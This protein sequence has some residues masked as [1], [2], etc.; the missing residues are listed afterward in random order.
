[1]KI[2]NAFGMV[3]KYNNVKILGEK[4]KFDQKNSTY[5]G[6]SAPAALHEEEKK[7]QIWPRAYHV[8]LWVYMP[9]IF[10]T[11]QLGFWYEVS[12][13]LHQLSFLWN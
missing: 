2:D 4:N 10:K 6:K 7:N 13:M 3:C 8:T 11:S 9:I 5:R 1:M 12:I